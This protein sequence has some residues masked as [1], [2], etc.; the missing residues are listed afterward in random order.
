MPVDCVYECLD[1]DL[2][3]FLRGCSAGKK[4]IDDVQSHRIIL[5]NFFAVDSK[6]YKNTNR[7]FEHLYRRKK[8]L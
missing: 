2:N 4:D 8:R 6:E 7:L 5:D 1:F 3:E